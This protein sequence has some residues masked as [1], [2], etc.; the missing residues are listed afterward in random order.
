MYKVKNWFDVDSTP[1]HRTYHN[2]YPAISPYH[3]DCSNSEA[4][5]I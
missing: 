5:N 4:D 2:T 3:S 1:N